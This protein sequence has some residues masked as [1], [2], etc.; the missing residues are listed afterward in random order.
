[1]APSSRSTLCN[2]AR[3]LGKGSQATSLG[4]V[5]VPEATSMHRASVLAASR[6]WT[7]SWGQSHIGQRHQASV[8]ATAAAQPVSSGWPQHPQ[9]VSLVEAQLSRAC[10]Q[11]VAQCLHLAGE[12]TNGGQRNPTQSQTQPPNPS[13]S[14]GSPWSAGRQG[15]RLWLLQALL[16][17][18]LPAG[19]HCLRH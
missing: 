15:W 10:G 16:G 2:Q 18:W 17:L 8:R 6:G 9:D 7:W 12:T 5:R 4:V 1:M 3:G 13:V 11:M 19:T 14:Q